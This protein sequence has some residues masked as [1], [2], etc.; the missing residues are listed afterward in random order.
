MI[1]RDLTN[2]NRRKIT[3]NENYIGF[4]VI[5]AIVLILAN[6]KLTKGESTNDTN[7][8]ETRWENSRFQRTEDYGCHSL[9]YASYR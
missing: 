1:I 7:S 2:F 4:N 3:Q 9:S 6:N 8:C 5:F